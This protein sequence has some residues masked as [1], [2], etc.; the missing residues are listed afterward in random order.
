MT[1]GRPVGPGSTVLSGLA[2]PVALGVVALSGLVTLVISGT[3]G[4]AAYGFGTTVAAVAAIVA[5]GGSTLAYASGTPV[6]RGAVLYVRYR[7]V[8]PILLVVAGAAGVVAHLAIGPGAAA[9]AVMGGLTVCFTNLAELEDYDYYR[10]LA[11]ARHAAI[12]ALTRLVAVPVALLT[13]DFALAMTSAAALTWIVLKVAR[14]PRSDVAPHA[15]LRAGLRAAIRPALLAYTLLEVWA[16]RWPLA[17]SAFVLSPAAADDFSAVMTIALSVSGLVLNLFAVS[18]GGRSGGRGDQAILLER[19]GLA[20]TVGGTTALAAV[21]PPFLGL[22]VDQPSDPLV[23]AFQVVLAAILVRGFA[24]RLQFRWL[25]RRDYGA[26]AVVLLPAAA[27]IVVFPL[28][29]A[30]SVVAVAVSVLLGEVV[31]LMVALARPAPATAG[32]KR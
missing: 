6:T 32:Q 22:V 5:A 16:L 24:R 29:P 31:S 18:M 26:A 23:L 19:L 15:G 17:I 14:P 10:H 20:V 28:V 4:V 30:V 13:H 11:V 1:A 27:A 21:A 7:V 9:P 12:L 25:A 3:S 2:N 8:T